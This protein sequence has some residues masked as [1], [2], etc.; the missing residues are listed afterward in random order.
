MKLNL[1]IPGIPHKE[2]LEHSKD[3]LFLDMLKEFSRY[4]PFSDL[5]ESKKISNTE[6]SQSLYSY[7]ECDDHNE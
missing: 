5:N 4:S 2:E 7:Y 3:I 6:D 1:S